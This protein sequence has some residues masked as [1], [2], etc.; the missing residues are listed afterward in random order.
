MGPARD[1]LGRAEAPDWMQL[2]ERLAQRVRNEPHVPLGEDGFGCDSI[3][4]RI[5]SI[6]V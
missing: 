1:V 4:S 6:S 3:R 5:V 2:D